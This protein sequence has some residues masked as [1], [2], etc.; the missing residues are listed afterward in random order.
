MLNIPLQQSGLRLVFCSELA[1][2]VSVRV[3][4]VVFI[5]LFSAV[6]SKLYRGKSKRLACEL[7]NSIQNIARRLQVKHKPTAFA[8]KWA[9]LMSC[10]APSPSLTDRQCQ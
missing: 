5:Q 8:E 2:S 7:F 3:I 1:T 4:N 10:D 9:S 6:T